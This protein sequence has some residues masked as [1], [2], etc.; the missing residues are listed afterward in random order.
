MGYMQI[1]SPGWTDVHGT[2]AQR[3][4]YKYDNSANLTYEPDGYYFFQSPQGDAVRSY[5][6]V[7]LVRD[8]N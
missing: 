2:G 6:Y 5:N 4:D 8:A 3:S 1:P 7:R